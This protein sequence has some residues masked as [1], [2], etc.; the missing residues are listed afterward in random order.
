MGTSIRWAK[1]E[2]EDLNKQGFKKEAR[3][4]QDHIDVAEVAA[5]LADKKMTDMRRDEWRAG[6]RQLQDYGVEVPACFQEKVLQKHLDHCG[7]AYHDEKVTSYLE[8]VIPWQRCAQSGVP[9]GADAHFDLLSPSL[10]NMEK[11]PK[12]KASFFSS[13]LCAWLLTA[14]EEGEAVTNDLLAAFDKALDF[15]ESTLPDEDD[16]NWDEQVDHFSTCCNALRQLLTQSGVRWAAELDVMM[17]AL[18]PRKKPPP[19][20][21]LKSIAGA[22]VKHPWWSS[23]HKAWHENKGKMKETLPTLEKV[24]ASAD[25]EGPL[26]QQL[27]VALE[28]VKCMSLVREE[29][30]DVFVTRQ[31][32]AN[33]KVKHIGD[34][35][36]TEMGAAHGQG[37]S[38]AE[39]KSIGHAVMKLLAK[40]AA[41][42]PNL[43]PWCGETIQQP[44]SMVESLSSESAGASLRSAMASF[45][46]AG[47]M[48]INFASVRDVQEALSEVF[49]N[50]DQNSPDLAEF[51][52]LLSPAVPLVANYLAESHSPPDIRTAIEVLG[53]MMSCCKGSFDDVAKL[54]KV[55]EAA[56][57]LAEACSAWHGLAETAAERAKTDASFEKI[58]TLLQG[59]A[60]LEATPV[61]EIGDKFPALEGKAVSLRANE[62]IQ[63]A[64]QEFI[65]LAEQGVKEAREKL[66]A[67]AKG[68]TDGTEWHHGHDLATMTYTTV[69]DL[70]K[71]SLLA[72]DGP[73]FAA[74]LA[75]FESR[76]AHRTMVAQLFSHALDTTT[77]S[78]D[79]ELGR[80]ALATKC[81]ALALTL[82]EDCWDHGPSKVK[83]KRVLKRLHEQTVSGSLSAFM[84]GALIAQLQELVPHKG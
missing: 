38:L 20:D 3:D 31:A 71:G 23:L 52:G 69:F 59:A 40:A 43:C 70:A 80:V 36:L 37:R 15:F 17:Q 1:K 44:E 19:P 2:V 76:V 24:F 66:A 14:I 82:L 58:R 79:E 13:R 54:I 67:T 81:T 21:M 5:K 56:L 41:C 42:L 68:T 34:R 4:L 22:V 48:A 6:L 8:A 10:S 57:P 18:E 74:T 45:C 9:G 77:T 64:C 46:P 12:D 49:A 33:E 35:A 61:Q 25:G 11:P 55:Q 47:A 65:Q 83:D 75:D 63:E 72:M 53:E 78:N 27:D 30:P 16:S 32:Q 73:R 29:L 50:H 7:E 39:R 60:S 26:L 28:I 84:L 51:D 62:Y